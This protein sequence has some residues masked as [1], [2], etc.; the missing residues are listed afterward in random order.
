MR[1]SEAA[2]FWVILS[3]SS[4][5]LRTKLEELRFDKLIK[6]N[7]FITPTTMIDLKELIFTARQLYEKKMFLFKCISTIFI[8]S[9]LGGKRAVLT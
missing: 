8:H 5:E 4:L 1:G 9:V 2:C 7:D 3:N 6:K